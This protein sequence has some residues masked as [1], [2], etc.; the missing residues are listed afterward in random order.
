MIQT[1]DSANG[2]TYIA[3]TPS[4]LSAMPPKR[5]SQ[6]S[7]T[8]S[9]GQQSTLS[10][11]GKQ[12]KVTKPATAQQTKSAKKAK[13]L[14]DDVVDI[15]TQPEADQTTADEAIQQQAEQPATTVDAAPDPLD[16]KDEATTTEDILGGRAQQSDVGALGGK[17]SGWVADEE[18]R[19]RKITD[20][21]IKQ[22]W[23]QKE[24]ERLAPRVHQQ[25]LTVYEKVLR[26]WDMSNQYGVSLCACS[27][28]AK[29]RSDNL[30]SLA[31][32]S[33]VSRGG[34]EPICSA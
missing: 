25:D 15:E 34:R 6:V 17:G 33:H 24:Q 12:N 32:E 4:P 20:T 13:V 18:E 9:T 19:A 31:S 26:E 11:H 23:R 30:Y 1:L 22:Y 7:R 29:N 5:R 3:Y 28:S 2:Q 10:F 21:R 8:S 27:T 16:I 14:V